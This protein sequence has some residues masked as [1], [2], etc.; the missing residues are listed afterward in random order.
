[1]SN[2]H[3][4]SVWTYDFCHLFSMQAILSLDILIH[5]EMW[6]QWYKCGAQ[7]SLPVNHHQRGFYFD[8][9]KWK[10]NNVIYYLTDFSAVFFV[11]LMFH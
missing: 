5:F 7:L 9:E 3:I 10:C 2:S 1:M 4:I 6:N 11:A 8:R